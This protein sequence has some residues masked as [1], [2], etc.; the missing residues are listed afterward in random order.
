[1]DEAQSIDAQ[2]LLA[3]WADHA[4]GD[5]ARWARLRP[6]PPLDAVTSRL[7]SAPR[8]FLDDAVS[9]VALAGDIL[10]GVHLASLPFVGDA[11][12]RTGAAIGLW[13]L[14]SEDVVE[15]FT[16]A[17]AVAG[18]RAGAMAV[19]ALALRLAPVAEPLTW[20]SEDDRREEAARTFL[21]WSGYLP[22]GEDV[23][24]AREQL[25]G[26]DSLQRNTAL[27]EAFAA[28]SHRADIARR[29]AEARAKEAAARYS[30]E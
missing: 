12:V 25:A 16:P 22:A 6:G 28:Q 8:A 20:L 13:L 14:A 9:L 10:S 15:A 30:S 11:R 21:L 1:M 24:T 18:P 23:D 19:D 17:L 29:L 3:A 26:R 4:G 27:A 5:A 7:S 2:D